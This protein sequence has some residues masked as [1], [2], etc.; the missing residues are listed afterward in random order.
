MSVCVSEILS[1][2]LK[3]E[4]KTIE[5]AIEKITKQY[6][7]ATIEEIDEVFKIKIESAGFTTYYSLGVDFKISSDWF[8][9]EAIETFKEE[10]L[11]K[12][13]ECVYDYLEEENYNSEEELI[14]CSSCEQLYCANCFSS[15]SEICYNCK[16]N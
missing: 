6:C 5:K 16:N 2:Y 11:L 4:L 7:I 12:C 8:I 9:N 14:T 10:Q 3:D 15:D 1:D 13:L